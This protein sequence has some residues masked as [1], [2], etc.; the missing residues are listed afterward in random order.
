MNLQMLTTQEEEDL[1]WVFRD[2]DDLGGGG[3][4]ELFGSIFCWGGVFWGV[5]FS[6]SVRF[7]LSWG[8]L[9][10]VVMDGGGGV[11]RRR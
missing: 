6:F 7:L 8:Y 4:A 5:L 10:L 2:Y 1:S 9:A 3:V 11:F